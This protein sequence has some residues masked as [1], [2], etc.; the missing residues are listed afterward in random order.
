VDQTAAHAETEIDVVEIE[1]SALDAGRLAGLDAAIIP[2]PDALPEG[3]WRRVRAFT[4]A[5]G[6][7][8]VCPPAQAT[9]HLWADAM[10]RD[11]GLT[12]SAG[13]EA[14]KYPKDMTI[15]VDKSETALRGMLAMLVPEMQ[16]LAAPVKVHEVLPV[17][18]GA[19]GSVL[20]RLE[21]GSPLVLASPPGSESASTTRGMVVLLTAAPALEWTDLQSKPLMV[22]LTQELVRQGV[23]RARGTYSDIAGATPEVPGRAVELRPVAEGGAVLKTTGSRAADP[24]R[25]AGVWRAV[26]ETGAPRGVVVVNADPAGGR[27]DPQPAPGIAAWL[28]GASSGVEVQWLG[29]ENVAAGAPGTIGAVLQSDEDPGRLALPLLIAALALAAGELVLARLFSHATIQAGG[30]A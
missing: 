1:P 23:G 26:D 19:R 9:V 2:R 10:I 12:W 28:R 29:G 3:S 8:L 24:V 20:L 27:T 11:L 14:R 5:G 21:D 13:R 6:F 7:V 4:D 16:D 15:A 17:E 25:R 22:A 18:T 30:A